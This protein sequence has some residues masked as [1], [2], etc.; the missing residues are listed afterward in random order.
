M[1]L[2]TARNE[3]T[4]AF[5]RAMHTTD[6]A[7]LAVE[8]I[9]VLFTAALLVL[10][11]WP[12]S[13]EL[14]PPIAN[15]LRIVDPAYPSAQFLSMHIYNLTPVETNKNALDLAVTNVVIAASH[16]PI[17]IATNKTWLI[18]FQP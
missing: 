4:Q 15:R 16:E 2:T 9:G 11:G 17:V 12:K 8:I 3:R 18:R 13:P 5:Y 10:A 1:T 14:L 6:I 7:R